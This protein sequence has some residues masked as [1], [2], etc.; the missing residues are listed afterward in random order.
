MNKFFM[1]FFAVFTYLLYLRLAGLADLN[2]GN[3]TH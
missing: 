3:F 2:H 1:Y